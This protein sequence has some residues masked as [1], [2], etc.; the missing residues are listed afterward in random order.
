MNDTYDANL[1]GS[2]YSSNY[3]GRLTA[4][5]YT[6][7]I[8]PPGLPYPPTVTEIYSYHAA[9]AVTGKRLQLSHWWTASGQGSGKAV[10]NP[11]VGY[12]YT[13]A[14]LPVSTTV[15]QSGGGDATSQDLFTYPTSQNPVTYTTTYD[16]MSRPLSMTDNQYFDRN[17]NVMN[18]AQSGVY[19]LAGR[20]TSFRMLTSFSAD[21]DY[22]N[23]CMCGRTG[24]YATQTQTYNVNGQLATLAWSGSSAVVGTLTYGYSSTQN[25]GQITQVTDA[26]SGETVVY[27][28]D[29]LKRLTSA[30]STPN[31]GSAPAA[32]TETYG[33]DGF[34]NLTSKVLNGTTTTIGVNAA[35]NRLSGA[36]YDANGN[37]TSGAGGTVG[38]D[39]ANR[40]VSFAPVSGGTEYYAYAPDNKRIYRLKA[41]GVT[42]E[43]SLYGARGEKLGVYSVTGATTGILG[44]NMQKGYLYFAG[45][46]IW[47]GSGA[48]FEDRLGTNRASWARFRPYG[49]EITSSANDREKFGTYNRD[50]FSGLDYADQRYYASSPGRFDTPDPDGAGAE[51]GDSGSWNRYAYT[52]GDP[53]NRTDA[54]GQAFSFTL[55]FCGS[56]GS[57]PCDVFGFGRSS[58]P[59]NGIIGYGPCDVQV[60]FVAGQKKSNCGGSAWVDAVLAV[61]EPARGE[62]EDDGGCAVTD[63]LPSSGAGFY[64]YGNRKKQFGVPSVI[65]ALIES[66]AVWNTRNPGYDIGIG[67]IS[68]QWGGNSGHQ[69]HRTGVD[70]DIRPLRNDGQHLGTNVNADSYNGSLTASLI[71]TITDFSYRVDVNVALVFFNDSSGIPGTQFAQGHEDHFHVRFDAACPR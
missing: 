13:A 69:S 36:S 39:E 11:D 20:M 38:Y 67:E 33:Y 40:M 52:A 55:G 57:L 15:P 32:W 5:Q 14:G 10:R 46:L 23:Q 51:L 27:Q 68:L 28:Y 56:Y 18:Y 60:A 30:A 4:A 25:N 59:G 62:D 49:D 29:A 21:W 6:L 12:T 9:G 41:D 16:S 35:T 53:V 71:G 64:S 66:A 70:V 31:V 37:M 43:L 34:G 17:S 63:L 42:E 24:N 2:T 45:R 65:E 22:I 48:V 47:E 61:F 7:C 26:V 3:Q 19:D 1:S 44:V 58:E 50:G 8:V 54:T